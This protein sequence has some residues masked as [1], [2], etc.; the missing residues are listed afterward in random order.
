[1]WYSLEAFWVARSK[2]AADRYTEHRL[3]NSIQNDETSVYKE[4]RITSTKLTAVN[5]FNLIMS[6]GFSG[7]FWKFLSSTSW[8]EPSG[9]LDQTISLSEVER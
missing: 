5:G 3:M 4:L 9:A 2:L 7:T 6:N 1:M 8:K